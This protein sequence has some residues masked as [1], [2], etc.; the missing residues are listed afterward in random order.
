[1]YGDAYADLW[2]LLVAVPVL[3]PSPSMGDARGSQVTGMDVLGLE[4]GSRSGRSLL[5]RPLSAAMGPELPDELADLRSA[6]VRRRYRGSMLPG[7]H[8]VAAHLARAAGVPAFPAELAAL[9]PDLE[10]AP[11]WSSAVGI[12]EE[13]P[14]GL[15]TALREPAADPDV[16]VGWHMADALETDPTV[17]VDPEAW[18]R[19]RLFDLLVGSWDHYVGQWAFIRTPGSAAGG[20]RELWIPAVQDRDQ[21][22]SNYGGLIPWIGRVSQ[23]RFGR[24]GAEFEPVRAGAWI[25]RHADRRFGPEADRDDFTA[26]A[27]QLER[28]LGDST[29]HAALNE[30][31]EAY[32]DAVRARLGDA[33]RAR[34]DQLGVLA[35][36]YYAWLSEEVEV[37]ARMGPDHVSITRSEDGS[38]ELRVC[39]AAGDTPASLPSPCPAEHALFQRMFRPGETREVYLYLLGGPD[40]VVVAGPALGGVVVRVV[41]G[42]EGGRL[43]SD[44]SGTVSLPFDSG[45]ETGPGLEVAPDIWLAP[46]LGVIELEQGARDWGRR[47]YW[48]PRAAF[49]GD[50]GLLLGADYISERYGFRRDPYRFRHRIGGVINPARQ[51]ARFD[52]DGEWRPENRRMGFHVRATSS[53]IDRLNYFGFGNETPRTGPDE[54]YEVSNW[55]HRAEFAWRFP[56]TRRSSLS[57]G[58][59]IHRWSGS[60][61]ILT[62]GVHVRHTRTE[63]EEGSKL[64]QD[65]PY[66][67]EAITQGGLRGVFTYNNRRHLGQE[68][69]HLQPG[70]YA[71]TDVPPPLGP[72]FDIW[73]DGVTYPGGLG[74]QSSYSIVRGSIR[75]YLFL[76]ERG[77]LLAL[78]ASGQRNFGAYPYYDAAFVGGLR[79][80]GLKANRY[81]GDAAVWFNSEL[82]IRVADLP[83][84]AGSVVGVSAIA[85]VGRVFYEGEDSNRWHGGYGA[86]LWWAPKES[87]VVNLSAVRGPEETNWY[88]TLGFPF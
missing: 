83:N 12:V 50:Y 17:R 64:A 30:L 14:D 3:T 7:A 36:E 82:R 71:R 44:G 55:A 59:T 26:A 57:S 76:A 1:M 18:A 67:V 70:D 68:E 5:F 48:L 74:L 11:D 25:A 60:G 2:R 84:P 58:G 33:L 78:A 69:G 31:P 85:D 39:A 54:V 16:L 8:L 80:R 45:R 9:P 23:P 46:H 21:A 51:R 72:G 15:L 62:L 19:A 28:S 4:V 79:V 35:E 27:R 37:R 87:L 42:A 20:A 73:V 22:F 24:F 86:G 61:P 10:I 34:R 52:Y 65:Q 88:L 32:P 77:P 63:L 47:S 38:V 81:A 40:Q 66:G 13:V 29:I 53:G 6:E 41:P 56:L 49:K 75:G 43:Q